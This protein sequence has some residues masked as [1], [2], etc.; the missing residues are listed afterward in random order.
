VGRARPGERLRYALEE[1]NGE[2]ELRLQEWNAARQMYELE[3]RALEIAT[4]LQ[5]D[6]VVHLEA[7]QDF[8][9]RQLLDEEQVRLGL[10][11]ELERLRVEAAELGRLRVE[12]AEVATLLRAVQSRRAYRY[13]AKMASVARKVLFPVLVVRRRLR[14]RRARTA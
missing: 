7:S 14:A 8:L 1:R 10:S 13:A 5:S 9:R 3:F 4:R 2:L 6:Y 12:F 11:A